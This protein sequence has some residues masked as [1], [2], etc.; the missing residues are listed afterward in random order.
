MHGGPPWASR[1]TWRLHLGTEWVIR[2]CGSRRLYGIKGVGRPLVPMGRCDWLVWIIAHVDKGLKILYC[3]CDREGC[4]ARA[5]Y[6][7]EQS[8]KGNLYL[9]H[10]ASSWISIDVKAEH[11]RYYTIVVSYQLTIKSIAWAEEMIISFQKS[12]H[13]FSGWSNYD[14]KKL[15]EATWR[16]QLTQKH[17]VT[18]CKKIVKGW[19]AYL[20]VLINQSFSPGPAPPLRSL[21]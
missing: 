3:L 7:R 12:H 19:S 17:M 8:R 6:L 11:N 10:L 20:Y 18:L 16:V 9:G 1:A 13:L 21:F 15:A 5:P 14:E 4:V 2:G